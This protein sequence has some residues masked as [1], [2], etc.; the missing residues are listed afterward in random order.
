MLSLVWEIARNNPEPRLTFEEM[1]QTG[2]HG[3]L[4]GRCLGILLGIECKVIGSRV[5][6]T[7]NTEFGQVGL[8]NCV[9]AGL[10]RAFDTPMYIEY[11]WEGHILTCI[12]QTN[13]TWEP[14]FS[15]HSSGRVFVKHWDGIYNMGGPTFPSVPL[16][17]H[18]NL[19]DN[20]C[21]GLNT[22]AGT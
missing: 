13:L 1:E 22:R 11:L 9:T 19:D 4:Q 15:R 7:G 12:F 2:Q 20:K 6:G 21:L 3:A 14:P 17:S 8:T 18:E 16:L 5:Q 10:F